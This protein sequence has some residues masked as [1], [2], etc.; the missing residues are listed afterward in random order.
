V[1]GPELEAAAL[2][3]EGVEYLE[4]DVR[5]AAWNPAS[6]RWEPGTVILQPWEVPELH[7]LTVVQGPPLEAGEALGIPVESP[8]VSLP[9]PPPALPQPPAPGVTSGLPGQPAVVSVPIPTLR[10]E[11]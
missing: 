10:E 4:G 3:V 7:E 6:A 5:V 2:Q 11:C 8:P 9:A 1:H